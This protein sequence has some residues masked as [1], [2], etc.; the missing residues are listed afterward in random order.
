MVSTPIPPPNLRSLP[1]PSPYFHRRVF[2]WMPKRMWDIVQ[3]PCQDSAVKRVVPSGATG[4][5]HQ[6]LLLLGCR[7]P[8]LQACNGTFIAWDK[9]I[10]DQLP[11]GVRQKFPV[12]LTYKYACD[13]A[14][15]SLLR[16]RTLGNS[17]GDCKTASANS[18]ARNG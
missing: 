11:S 18:T 1:T 8:L 16:S 17:P 3:S 5:G 2:L 4:P 15:M 7:V 9:R 14:V 13:S 10:L 6:G 12:I